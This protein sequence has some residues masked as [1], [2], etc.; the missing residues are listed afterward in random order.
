MH[1]VPVT[2]P[3]Q[4]LHVEVCRPCQFIWFDVAEFESL[5]AAPP[6]VQGE[7]PPAAREQLALLKVQQLAEQAHR[8]GFAEEGP[9]EPWKAIP[10]ILGLPVE[11]DNPI[12]RLP[13]LTWGL[14]AVLVLTSV[15]A[16]RDPATAFS[17]FGFIAA[18]AW[19]LGGLTWLS[20]FFL[21]GGLVHLIANLYFLLI[22]GDNVEEVL[23]RVRYAGLLLAAT[24]AG[25]GVYL[26][27]Q[28]ASTV[29]SIGAS[30]G[31]SG[32][33]VFYALQF[34]RAQLAIL[35]RSYWSFRWLAIPAWAA[36][37]LWV[38]LQAFGVWE[39]IE[40]FSEV[41]ALAHLGGAG[42]GFVV[43]LMTRRHRA[44]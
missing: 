26:L 20:A 30:G 14:A 21:H 35:L 6:K 10:A 41:N 27:F 16:W 18:E 11:V 12:S 19:R 1:E 28:G 37:G 29:P 8:E 34:P 43:W 32:V 15:L 13:W 5:P 36:L 44:G 22:F 25:H 4:T 24:L 17:Q 7:L 2:A 39:Q 3:G 9:E 23:G 33:I 38:L 40:G 31:I 42:A